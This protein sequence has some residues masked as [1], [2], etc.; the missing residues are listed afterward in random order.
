MLK[1]AAERLKKHESKV[2]LVAGDFMTTDFAAGKTFD[3]ATALGV[4]DYV[5]EP[6]GFIKKAVCLTKGRFIASF[7]RSGTPRSFIRSVRLSL[8]RR[9]VYFYSE[10]QLGSM[11]EK[12]GAVI[13]KHE[14][15]GQLHCVIFKPGRV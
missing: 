2:T 6:L 1:I 14:I 8:K 9:P 3:V 4:F 5:A 13:E 11:A 7:P 15:I 12:C 10:S